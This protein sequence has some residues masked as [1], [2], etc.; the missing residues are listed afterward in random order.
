M[1]DELHT[2]SIDDDACD[3]APSAAGAETAAAAAEPPKY[4]KGRLKAKLAFWKLF[5]T[6]AWVLSW[7]TDG[8][9]IPW[10]EM[11]LPP[12]HAFA[13]QQGALRHHDFVT[14]EISDLLARGSIIQT[15][16]P[17]LVVNPF[18]VVEHNS[19]LRL[20]LD[21]VYVNHFI[22]KEGLK[23]KYEGIKLT[24]LYF[25]PDDYMF[26]VDLEKAYHHVDMHQS[27][28]DYLGFSWLGKTYTFTVMPFGL[29]PACWVFTKLTNE[30]VGHWRAQGIRLVHYLDDF[31]F[32]VAGDANGGHSFFKS[33]QQRVL[34]DIQAAGF[35]LS[36]PKLVLAPQKSI[37]FLGYVVDLGANRLT[38]DPN[39]V[40]KLKAI[41]GRLQASLRRV[42][43]AP[44]PMIIESVRLSA[45]A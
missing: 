20:I 12:P 35:S 32:A 14:G 24:S 28:W 19:K 41:L 8:Y 26:S 42:C 44:I 21:L 45:D 30:L 11:G 22:K 17:P 34:S 40:L 10:G 36:I 5:C 38:V 13:N 2:D 23:F 16:R 43:A 9:Q 18:N 3:A 39:R 7:I 1:R 15:D 33:V 6:S 37:K 25:T 27:T 4:I 29:C 31:L